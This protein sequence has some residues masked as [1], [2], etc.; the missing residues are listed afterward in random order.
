MNKAADKAPEPEP[1][2]AT[3]KAPAA[4][5]AEPAPSVSKAEMV[6]AA[7]AD[8]I[9][10][11]GDGVEYI[12]AK[13]GIDLPKPMWSSYRAQQKAKDNK[14]APKGKPGRKPK[15]ADS[16]QAARTVT[17]SADMIDDLSAVKHLVQKLGAEQVHKIVGLFE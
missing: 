15:E 1:K 9:D 14:D 5:L 8:G 7:L 6:R 17:A 10:S 11:P 4:P 13:Y 3:A 16:P 2:K 12:K